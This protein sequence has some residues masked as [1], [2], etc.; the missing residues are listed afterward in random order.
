MKDN[1]KALFISLAKKQLEAISMLYNWSECMIYSNDAFFERRRVR[2]RFNRCIKDAVDIQN[3]L[4]VNC[5]LSND[6]VSRLWWAIPTQYII[7]FVL[8][9]IPICNISELHCC[10]YDWKIYGEREKIKLCIIEEGNISKFQSFSSQKKK[11]ESNYSEIERENMIEDYKTSELDKRMKD[12]LWSYGKRVHSLD[13]GRYYESMSDYYNSLEYTA[14]T[15]ASRMRYENDLSCEHHI[16][17][18][19]SHSKSIFYSVEYEVGTMYMQNAG[20]VGGIEWG[21]CKLINQ[22]CEIPQ[23]VIDRYK[24]INSGILIGT[25]IHNCKDIQ[26]VNVELFGDYFMQP[27]PNSAMAVQIAAMMACFADKIY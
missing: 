2:K 16:S 10:E 6:E 15:E 13:T 25:F 12:E 27:A 4:R 19:V 11:I 5:S 21:V 18:L 7:Q 24:K 9:S 17:S 26:K 1:Q 22:E 20:C 8:N 3:K 23:S 14:L